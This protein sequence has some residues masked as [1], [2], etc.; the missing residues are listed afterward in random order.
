VTYPDWQEFLGSYWIDG[1]RFPQ[2][3]AETPTFMGCPHATRPEDLEGADVVIIGSPYVTSWTDEW[4]GVPKSEWTAA[5]QRVRQ[6][7]VRYP[8]AYI[9]DFDLDVFEHLRVVDYGDAELPPEVASSQTVDM[10]RRAQAAVEEKVNAALDAGAMPV[11]IGQNSPCS[12]FAIANCINGH[13]EGPMGIVSLDCHWDVEP[14]DRITLDSSI[15]GPACWLRHTLELEHVNASNVIEIGPRG[16]LEDKSGIRELLAQGVRFHS[17]WE[18]R[19]R[20]IEAICAD[21][22]AAYNGTS[23]VYAHF[24]M[25][26]LG[27]A[28][29]APGDILGDLAEPIGMSDYEVIR[30]AHEVGLRGVDGFSF[31]CIPPGSAVQY[32]VIVY[33]IL[34][35]LAGVVIARQRLQTGDGEQPA[36]R[37]HLITNEAPDASADGAPVAAHARP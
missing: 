5:P 10:I 25:D 24:D 9:Q 17:S 20:G 26:V 4:A 1:R 2:I 18:V 35:L 29:P 12:S 21:L 28:G 27:G 8:T 11:V 23:R 3:A 36:A 16:M 15:A 30:I 33:V 6:Q 22:D 13:A 31:I 19:R 37:P 34:Y 32:R 14:I 7:S